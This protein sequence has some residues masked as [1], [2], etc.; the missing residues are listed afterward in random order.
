MTSCWILRSD[1]FTTLPKAPIATVCSFMINQINCPNCDNLIRVNAK[2][3]ESCGE[4]VRG[5]LNRVVY[6][7]RWGVIFA[8]VAYVVIKVILPML[9][10]RFMQLV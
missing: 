9:E 1:R 7:I 4:T 2:V 3:C 10:S 5:Q 8:V 6:F